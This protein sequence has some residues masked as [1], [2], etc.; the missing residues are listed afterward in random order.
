[1]R[2]ATDK[3]GLALE[4]RKNA[5]AKAIISQYLEKYAEPEA[6]LARQLFAINSISLT[7]FRH[8]L[9]I[10][11]F[12]ERINFVE[13]LAMRTN[14]S[15]I[16]LILVIN[17]TDGQTNWEQNRQLYRKICAEAREQS[18]SGNLNY[19]HFKRL[20][21]LLVDRFSHGRT[22]PSKQG[23]GLARKIGCDIAVQ[24][25][26]QQTV[27]SQWIHSSDADTRLPDNYFSA[28]T[29]VIKASAQVFDFEHI[30]TANATKENSTTE[31]VFTATQKYE[32]AL[33]YYRRGLAWAGSPY[34]FHTLGSCI[35]VD[36]QA[37]CHV[38]GFP[39]RAGG[40]DFYLLN[41]L[42]KIGAIIDNP[43]VKITIDAR[44]SNR[45]P[46]GT[47]PAVQKIIDLEQDRQIYTYYNPDIFALLR[48]WI[49]YCTQTLSRRFHHNNGIPLRLFCAANH[50]GF[51]AF[52]DHARAHCNNQQAFI[53]Q[54]HQWFDG[55]LT[56]KFMH[57]FRQSHLQD[58]PLERAINIFNDYN[59]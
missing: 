53:N 48:L 9:V 21:A 36:Y 19:V 17:Q 55:F 16:L 43:S 32:Q 4:Q 45:V 59:S 42:A 33:H 26:S 39:K 1:M 27:Q 47:G 14:P 41:K 51:F 25:I 57:Y 20:P 6:G 46:F 29:E 11:T 13:R 23:V 35:A 8:V 58:L 31:E 12:N 49:S 44:L 24:L 52:I 3:S 10:P 7:H 37:Y 38:R 30:Q 34:A 40:E 56:L 2:R 22:I 18:Q 15:E 54:F 50:L 28:S 5:M